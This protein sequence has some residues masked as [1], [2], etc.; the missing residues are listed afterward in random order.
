MRRNWTDGAIA[1]GPSFWL[2]VWSCAGR[3]R[4]GLAVDIVMERN[5]K[6]FFATAVPG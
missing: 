3:E 5:M 6:T 4:S 2:G 1:I